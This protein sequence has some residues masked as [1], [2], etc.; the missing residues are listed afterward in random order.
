M[1]IY[2]NELSKY[3]WFNHGVAKIFKP[4]SVDELKKFLERLYRKR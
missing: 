2:E 1:F 4:Q 3:N